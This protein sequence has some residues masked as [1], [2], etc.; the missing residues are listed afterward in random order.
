MRVKCLAFINILRWKRKKILDI[1]WKNAGKKSA[2]LAHSI[3]LNCSA[4]MVIPH[5]LEN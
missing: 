2:E 1:L 3:P 4:I 5:A